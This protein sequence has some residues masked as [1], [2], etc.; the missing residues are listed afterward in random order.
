[1]PGA[2]LWLS[3]QPKQHLLPAALASE[4]HSNG[5][6]LGIG[7]V[8]FFFN[9]EL[10]PNPLRTWSIEVM[11]LSLQIFISTNLPA[12]IDN[13]IRFKTRIKYYAVLRFLQRN[14]DCHMRGWVQWTLSRALSLWR[15]KSKNGRPKRWRKEMKGWSHWGMGDVPQRVGERAI[16]P[17]VF[18]LDKLAGYEWNEGK[19]GRWF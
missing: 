9:F 4:F 19:P 11:I 13:P 3:W 18:S 15:G 12:H 2:K 8:W 5:L 7:E 14:K 1:M 16:L 17:S 6:W 10:K